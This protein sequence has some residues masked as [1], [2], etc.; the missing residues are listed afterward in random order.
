MNLV[1]SV[2]FDG[3]FDDAVSAA[4]EALA[5]NGF[6]VLTEIDVG[7]TLKKKLDVEHPATLI[8][9]ACNPPLAHRALVAEP[10]VAAVL[11]CNVVVR[12]L[13][14]GQIEVAAMDPQIMAQMVDNDEINAVAKEVDARMQ[15]VLAAIQGAQ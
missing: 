15:K 2:L 11:P 9:G 8:L 12:Q 10:D 7:A 13:A 14:S 1:N 6:G 3:A 5:A 4:R